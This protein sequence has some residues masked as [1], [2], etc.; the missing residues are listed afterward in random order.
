[1]PKKKLSRIPSYRLHKPTGQGFVELNGKRHYL[2]RHDL[3][4]TRQNYHRL[5]GEWE[6]YGRQLPVH[7]EDLTVVE[8]CAAYWQ[9]AQDYYRTPDGR[10][11]STLAAVR[12]V[13]R[14]LDARYGDVAATAFGP[15]ALRSVRDSWIR[16]GL[17]RGTINGYVSV[18]KRMFKWAV[19]RELLPVETYQALATL[20][21]VR[22]GR[23]AAKE[24]APVGPVPESHIDAVKPYVSFQV[25][26]LV[27]LQLLTGSRSGELLG[28]RPVDLDCSADVWTASL[29]EHKTAHRGKERVLCF[30]P[31]AQTILRPFLQDR[32]LDAYLFS[33]REAV[34][35][36][37][38]KAKTHR[39]LEQAATPRQTN[40]VVGER[41]TV[42]S[43]RRAIGRACEKAGVPDW[44]PHQ[45]RHN[46]GT[47][48]RNEFGLDFAQAV[49][50]HS[51]AAIT[52]LYAEID[53]GKAMEVAARIG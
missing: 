26:A 15:Q 48:V 23:S 36:Q 52:E 3:A 14:C 25:W 45:L 41:Y 33:P 12:R 20:D 32:R 50:G 38:A 51:H 30:G 7:A 35:E 24:P 19:S 44:H 22:A 18:T 10:A 34:Q 4:K 1:M 11:S 17:A 2:G 37:A 8:L 46:A 49:L 9:Y 42:A 21:G 39:R 43:Y 47:R 13:T 6:A 16:D 53:R 28:L 40:R 27:Q 31:E 5:V 29:T